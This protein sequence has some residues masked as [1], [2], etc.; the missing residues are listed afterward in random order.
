MLASWYA[1]AVASDPDK[2]PYDFSF[3]RAG[4]SVVGT[5]LSTWLIHRR[6][7]AAFPAAAA[8]AFGTVALGAVHR[9]SKG[10]YVTRSWNK[11]SLKEKLFNRAMPVAHVIGAAVLEGAGAYTFWKRRFDKTVVTGPLLQAPWYPRVRKLGLYFMTFSM[12]GH[13]AEMLFCTGIKYGI[14]KGGYDRENHMLWDQWLFPFPAEGTAAVLADLALTP[15]KTAMQA[16][17]ARLPS[18]LRTPIA[19]AASFLVNQLACTSIDFATGMV[20]NRNYELWD[21][22][23]MRFNF[24]GQI[25]LQN[26]L[27]YSIAATWGVWQLL[28]SLEKLMT[29]AGDT[30]LDGALVGMGSFFIFLELLY[31]AVP[32]KELPST[33]K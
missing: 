6:S 19:L 16:G 12:L 32:P 5:A 9:L 15:A 17:A 4:A 21:Y 10:S 1:Y 23:D 30:I 13:W 33:E 3:W 24:M 8:T 29:K 26:S 20:A 7:P 25:C 31:Q 28:P 14:F 2:T 22:R 11:D 27:F 18:P